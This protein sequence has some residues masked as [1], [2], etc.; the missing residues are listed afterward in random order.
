MFETPILYIIYNRVEHVKQ[1][2]SQIIK[3]KPKKLFIAADGPDVLKNGDDYKCKV[4]RELVLSEINWA[5]EVKTL[6]RERNLGCKIAVS[7][8]I[9]W[10]FENVEQGIILEDDILPDKSF[11]YFCQELLIKYRYDTRIMQINGLNHFNSVDISYSYFF[12]KFGPCWGWA[13]W[14]RAWEKNDVNMTKWTEIK[15][16]KLY[17]SFCDSEAEQ[18]WRINLF[19]TIFNN[20]IDT[21][22]YQWVFTKLIESGLCITPKTNLIKNI[23]FMNDA[24]HTGTLP[25][26]M[27]NVKL[28]A[29]NFPL[30]HPEYILRN[31]KL[32]MEYFKSV[33]NSKNN[34]KI[35]HLIWRILSKIKKLLWEK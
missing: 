23:G 14:R 18:Q 28:N 20:N 16:K 21:W 3:T 31:A 35:K 19:D 33:V 13:T 26:Y 17:H 2:F 22:D 7:S 4:T 32:D 24:T 10:F 30:V 34:S 29:I 12:A 1:T 15:K 8:A 6:F 9:D 25:S 11:F 27:R 5:C